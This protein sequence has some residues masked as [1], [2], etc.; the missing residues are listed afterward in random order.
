MGS[1]F[2]I[3]FTIMTLKIFSVSYQYALSSSYNPCSKQGKY[4]KIFLKLYLENIHQPNNRFKRETRH[5]IICKTKKLYL[6]PH[7]KQARNY[8]DSQIPKS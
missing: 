7:T 2:S 6:N 4:D 3:Y 1:L 5:F 8:C